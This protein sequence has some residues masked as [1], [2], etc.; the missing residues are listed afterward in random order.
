MPTVTEILRKSDFDNRLIH[1]SPKEETWLIRHHPT[2][3]ITLTRN[4]GP[5]GQTFVVK[6]HFFD[7][8]EAHLRRFARKPLLFLAK[9]VRTYTHEVPPGETQKTLER[10]LQNKSLSYDYLLFEPSSMSV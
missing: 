9:Q 10:L 5:D 7:A 2:V 4:F 8:G 3:A 1:S 6:I